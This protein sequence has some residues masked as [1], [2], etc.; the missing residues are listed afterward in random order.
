MATEFNKS[1]LQ[2][3]FEKYSIDDLKKII[4]ETGVYAEMILQYSFE[5]FV[6][7]ST[8]VK[9]YTAVLKEK[10]DDDDGVDVTVKKQVASDLNQV[11]VELQYHD[12][13]RQKLEHIQFSY[14]ASMKEAK[15]IKD[16]GEVND[17]DYLY[18]VSENAQLTIHQFELIEEEYKEAC[19]Y[20]QSVLK[21]IENNKGLSELLDFSIKNSF[22][23]VEPLS[24]AIES[25]SKP[26]QDIV[27]TAQLSTDYFDEVTLEKLK[28][29]YSQYTMQSERG[30]FDKLFY[31]QD[32]VE[33]EEDIELF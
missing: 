10:M 31:G 8:K 3:L 16:L 29:I 33:E 11:I 20:I 9:P 13:I 5:D 1:T 24:K 23:N 28:R 32:V 27:N 15:D 21:T 6:E 12:I 14:E 4:E 22:N 30:I 17:T 19:T 18:I 7:L 25:L 2:H 26:L